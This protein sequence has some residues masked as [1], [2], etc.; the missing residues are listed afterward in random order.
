SACM[1]RITQRSSTDC[2]RFGK[3]S[4]TSMPLWPYLRN[5]KEDGNAVLPF[6]LPPFWNSA[7]SGF[8]DCRSSAGLGSK[9]ST[10]D[11]PP[12]AKIWITRLALPGKWPFRGESG[13]SVG[14]S[15]ARAWP[16]RSASISAPMPMPLRHS[17]SRRLIIGSIRLSLVD[18][19]ELVG[20]QKDVDVLV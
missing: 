1:P 19:D 13:L 4:L 15:S 2:A 8:P 3:I 9:V 11:G 12:L 17:S 5:L 7:G 10:C 18:K 16:I 20:F 14:A 6:V